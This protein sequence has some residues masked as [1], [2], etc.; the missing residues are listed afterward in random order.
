MKKGH[1]NPVHTV[2]WSPRNSN[3]LASGGEDGSIKFWDI[4]KAKACLQSLSVGNTEGETGH[5][6]TVTGLSFSSDGLFLVSAGSDKMIRLWDGF[7]G[8]YLYKQAKWEGSHYYETVK[9]KITLLDDSL[10][11][12]VF[13]PNHRRVSSYRL[14]DL[15]KHDDYKGHLKPVTCLDVCHR[16][17]ELVTGAADQEVL[18]WQPRLWWSS[19]CT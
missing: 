2:A 15:V 11:P 12:L 14:Y 6:G 18:L 9:P 3:L 17:F 8:Q 16:R 19:E 1:A 7:S 10:N 13:I 5:F 4:R